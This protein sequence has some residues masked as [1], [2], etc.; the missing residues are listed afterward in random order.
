MFEGDNGGFLADQYCATLIRGLARHDVV[1]H[2]GA[3]V[4][5]EASFP[6][7]TTLEDFDEEPG[8]FYFA[9][10]DTAGCAL[11]LEAFSTVG[12]DHRE[13]LSRDA[14]LVSHFMI[15][16]LVTRFC[17]LRDTVTLLDFQ[18]FY[19]S[20]DDVADPALAAM[21]REA[22]FLGPRPKHPRSATPSRRSPWRTACSARGS[23]GRRSSA[24]PS[25]TP[26]F[27]RRNPSHHG[28]LESSAAIRR[29]P[30]VRR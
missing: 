19:G 17:Y 24:Q 13:A 16:N 10:T 6:Q 22:G 5:Q 20:F 21:M 29:G 28:H 2:L 15:I 27:P 11:M 3:T 7:I 30:A 23:P 8:R 9:V 18:P 25:C 4:V 1:Q 14:A 26:A 12:F